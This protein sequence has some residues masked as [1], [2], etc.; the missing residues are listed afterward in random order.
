MLYQKP[1]NTHTS[2]TVTG[3]E[4]PKGEQCSFSIASNQKA[5]RAVSFLPERDSDNLI[6]IDFS[7]SAE[8]RKEYFPVTYRQDDR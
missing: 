4:I 8:S 1:V 7:C 5:R 2:L 6:A 3:G